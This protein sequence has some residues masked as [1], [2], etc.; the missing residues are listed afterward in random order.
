MAVARRQPKEARARTDPPAWRA[1]LH[2]GP[3][4][5]KIDTL[6]AWSSSPYRRIGPPRPIG[7]PCTAVRRSALS[8]PLPA[9]ELYRE[10]ARAGGVQP[11]ANAVTGTAPS[12]RYVRGHVRSGRI[13]KRQTHRSIPIPPFR[14]RHLKWG[15]LDVQRPTR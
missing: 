13:A 15:T 1:G 12:A 6:I 14:F 3:A 8:P 9:S 11:G 4:A 2:G 5:K 10:P 7:R